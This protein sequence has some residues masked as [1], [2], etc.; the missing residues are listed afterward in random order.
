MSRFIDRV[1]DTL[2][3]GGPGHVHGHFGGQEH[4]TTQEHGGAHEDGPEQ[5]RVDENGAPQHEHGGREGH[6]HC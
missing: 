3:G 2:R 1:R 4:G 5:E 6:R